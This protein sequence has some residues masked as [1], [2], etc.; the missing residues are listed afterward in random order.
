MAGVLRS[1]G[2]R[3]SQ[4]LNELL[5]RAYKCNTCHWSVPQPHK[6]AAQT[7]VVSAISA[8]A[9]AALVLE[10]P[11]P[12]YSLPLSKICLLS[13]PQHWDPSQW[14]WMWPK[15]FC[16]CLCC[17]TAHLSAPSLGMSSVNLCVLSL[18]PYSLVRET[19]HGTAS[20]GF[21]E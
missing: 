3:T 13:S 20:K 14:P 9:Q 2:M 16:A 11:L 15:V 8:N 18:N 6:L 10:V 19:A 5:G 21:V 17:D 4:N 1:K 7:L 12:S